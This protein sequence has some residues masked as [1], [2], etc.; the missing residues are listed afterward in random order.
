MRFPNRDSSK[1]QQAIKPTL[2]NGET[3]VFDGKLTLA[4]I[5]RLSDFNVVLRFALHTRHDIPTSGST[6]SSA[7]DLPIDTDHEFP[8]ITMEFPL[9]DALDPQP[10]TERLR[11]VGLNNLKFNAH[12]NYGTLSF[13][14]RWDVELP[15]NFPRKLFLR[16]FARVES[17]RDRRIVTTIN[18]YAHVRFKNPDGKLL[19]GML[20]YEMGDMRSSLYLC[21]HDSWK[22]P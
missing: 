19:P 11:C 21:F 5:G 10:I 14:L 8:M 16:T 22:V 4:N 3:F 2:I 17:T 18:N 15:Q 7:S 9:K 12:V 13:S 20:L 1:S 6:P